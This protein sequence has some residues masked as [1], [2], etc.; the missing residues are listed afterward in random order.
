MAPPST[1]VALVAAVASNGVIGREGGL[2]WRLASDLRRFRQLTMGKPLV[3]GRGT[4][5]SIGR[6]LP[7][8][9]NIVIC[10][11][12]CAVRGV[13]TAP[14]LAP[15]LALADD[16]ARRSGAQEIAVIGGARVFA[17]ALPLALRLYLTEVMAAPLGDRWMPPIDFGEWREVER[18]EVAASSSDDH[19]SRFRVLDRLLP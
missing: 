19:P 8:R 13:R 9:D 18:I 2:P 10:S 5:E 7:G 16:C 11:G 14:A 6:A 3:M 4:S 15:A 1:P 17:E 12:H